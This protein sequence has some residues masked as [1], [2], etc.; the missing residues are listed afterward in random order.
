MDDLIAI[1]R[2]DIIA[3]SQGGWT[4]SFGLKDEAGVDVDI[5]G[6][7]WAFRTESGLDVALVVDPENP[8]G[9]RVTLSEAQIAGI[10][11]QPDS[12]TKYAI[13]DTGAVPDIVL[14]YGRL[15]VEGW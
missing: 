5:S 6:E 14:A 9:L 13:V 15:A 1:P 4:Y 7:V 2:V 8:A 3:H 11:T 12:S 10:K